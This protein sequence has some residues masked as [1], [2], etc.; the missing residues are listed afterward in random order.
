MTEGSVLLTSAPALLDGFRG[1]G[2]TGRAGASSATY[3]DFGGRREG[4][5]GMGSGDPHQA[6]CDTENL[7]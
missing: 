7:T 2:A 6:L 5:R 3:L 4:E 1:F